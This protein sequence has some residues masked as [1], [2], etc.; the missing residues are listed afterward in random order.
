MWRHVSCTCQKRI[1]CT[2]TNIHQ[3]R[4]QLHPILWSEFTVIMWPEYTKPDCW[5]PKCSVNL[6]SSANFGRSLK[7]AVS[8]RLGRVSWKLHDQSYFFGTFLSF[9]NIT[10]F[11]KM[12]GSIKRHDSSRAQL[13]GFNHINYFDPLVRLL[14]DSSKCRAP[15]TLSLSF[16]DREH[17]CVDHDQVFEPFYHLHGHLVTSRCFYTWIIQRVGKALE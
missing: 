1:F 9:T 16:I 7:P 14:N 15:M 2:I 13:G 4:I 17:P 6:V 5:W 12:C 8:N 11:I 10:G 3:T